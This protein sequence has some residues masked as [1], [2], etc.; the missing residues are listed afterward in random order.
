MRNLASIQRIDDI[1]PIEGADAIEVA[2]I[3]GWNVVVKKGEFKIG[4]YCVY[5]EVD[6]SLPDKPEFDFLRTRNFRIR[7]I[8][9]K[10]QISQ[11]I[12]FPLDILLGFEAFPNDEN[13]NG[14]VFDSIRIIE[15]GDWITME[16]VPMR[17]DVRLGMD[18]TD[19]LGITKY[20]PP[21]PTQLSGK[22][23]GN[24]PSFLFKTDET[25]LQSIPEILEKLKGVPLYVTAKLDGSSATMYLNEDRFGVC[26]RNWD[27][28]E[29]ED[30]SFWK[31]ARQENIE[32]KLRSIGGNICIQGELMGEGV[33]GNKLKLSGLHFY[34]FQIYDID[35]GLYYQYDKFIKTC[36]D[37]NIK[38]VPIVDDNFSTFDTVDEYVQYVIKKS[39]INPNVW[40]EGYVFR[41]KSNEYKMYDISFKVINPEFLLNYKDE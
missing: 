25:R 4:D 2:R 34:A 1:Q 22:V 30:N 26:S 3:L 14:I 38:T 41:T 9:L 40:E 32:D 37:L 18:V 36:N 24:F 33:Q 8:K 12:C 5:C 11:G 23:R 29:T 10:G 39:I 16:F 13:L 20:E 7:T 27:L 21:I 19:I 31:V 28:D 15:P 35:A 6:S 17:L